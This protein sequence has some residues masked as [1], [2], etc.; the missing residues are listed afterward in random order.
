MPMAM[1][2]SAPRWIAG[3]IGVVMRTPPSPKTLP[4][5]DTGEKKIGMAASWDAS[6]W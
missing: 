2:L 6:V 1:I 4:S 3:L 5:I